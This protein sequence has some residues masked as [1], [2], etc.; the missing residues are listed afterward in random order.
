MNLANLDLNE[1]PQ[2]IKIWNTL[3]D[4]KKKGFKDFKIETTFLSLEVFVKGKR[5]NE[6]ATFGL[7]TKDFKDKKILKKLIKD[8]IKEINKS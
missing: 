6:T 7:A 8:Q 4:L 3:E 1:I 5:D 2:D